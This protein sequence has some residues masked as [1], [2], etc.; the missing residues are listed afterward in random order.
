MSFSV[1]IKGD[2]REIIPLLLAGSLDS[3]TAP[4]LQATINDAIYPETQALIIDMKHLEFISSAGLRIIFKTRKLMDGSGGKLVLINPQPQVRKV[5]DI[6][7]A[8]ETLSIFQNDA[9]LDE[10]L[11]DIQKNIVE[12]K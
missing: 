4:Q 8:A 11:A 2:S 9:E 7:K 1:D 3:D 12:G 10:Y 5:F 6:I